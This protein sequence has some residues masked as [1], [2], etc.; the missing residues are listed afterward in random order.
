MR[1]FFYV[2]LHRKSELKTMKKSLLIA[3]IIA[4]SAVLY[5]RLQ[6]R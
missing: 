6:Q 4:T 3:G 2:T 1:L 5:L